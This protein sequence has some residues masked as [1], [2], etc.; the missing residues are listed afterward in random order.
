MMSNNLTWDDLAKEYDANHTGRK[1]CTLP[2]DKV[3]D[4]AESRTDLFVLLDAVNVKYAK[5]GA[6]ALYELALGHYHGDG[7]FS[8]ARV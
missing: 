2:M 6:E 5:M 1:T 7:A 4:W 8:F 3:F